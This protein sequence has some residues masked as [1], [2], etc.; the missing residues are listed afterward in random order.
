MGNENLNLE[1]TPETI[2]ET[3]EATPVEAPKE[4]NRQA[5]DTVKFEDIDKITDPEQL[6]K[7]AKDQFAM[8]MRIGK[9][10][11]KPPDSKISETADPFTKRDFH[12]IN[13][14]SAIEQ[15]TTISDTDSEETKQIKKDLNNREIWDEVKRYYSNKSGRDRVKDIVE[16]IFDAH[17]AWKRRGGAKAPDTSKLMAAELARNAGKGGGGKP[18]IPKTEVKS[19]LPPRPVPMSE[20]FVKKS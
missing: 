15:V 6:K 5:P 13:E 17:A 1:V 3:P 11:E 2:N 12:K 20:W 16:D 9:K 8:R 14:K 19:T 18:T 10:L 4:E 7:I